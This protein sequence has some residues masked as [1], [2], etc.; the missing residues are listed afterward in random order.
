M[1]VREATLSLEEKATA[2]SELLQ[3]NVSGLKRRLRKRLENGTKHTRV[4]MSNSWS[5]RR[6][7]EENAGTPDDSGYESFLSLVS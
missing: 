3:E 7:G 6:D 2:S 5:E 1:A 4:L